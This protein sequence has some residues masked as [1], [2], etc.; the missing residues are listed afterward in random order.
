MIAL[1]SPA[2]EGFA[3]ESSRERSAHEGGQETLLLPA[4]S[5]PPLNVSHCNASALVSALPH[6]PEVASHCVSDNAPP[7]CS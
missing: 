2:I 6:L 4:C 1:S 7:G 3:G 5:L